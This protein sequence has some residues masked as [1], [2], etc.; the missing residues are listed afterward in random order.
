MKK[1]VFII[2]LSSFSLGA[3]SQI[4]D[5]K[6]EYDPDLNDI[7][8]HFSNSQW[9][10][11][12]DKA[13]K[14]LADIYQVLNIS[15][16]NIE[17]VECTAIHSS[18][19]A[20]L[21]A[22]TLKRYILINPNRLNNIDTHYFS[23]LFVIAHEFGHHR[24][25]HFGGNRVLTLEDKRNM[26]LEADRFG[27]SIV[28][29][30]G[31]SISDCVFALNEMNHP[32]NDTYYDHPTLE[33]RIKA[34]KEGFYSE[35]KIDSARHENYT[36]YL[37]EFS[38]ISLLS[39]NSTVSP[40]DIN[41]YCKASGLVPRTITF[42]NNKYWVYWKKDDNVASWQVLWNYSYDVSLLQKYFDLGYNLNFIEEIHGKWFMVFCKFN[43]GQ[44][45]QR[46]EVVRT[47]DLVVQS[48]NYKDKIESKLNDGY[49]I[50]DL[51][52]YNTNGD[53]L[54]VLSKKIQE[55]KGWT[56]AIRN[57]YEDISQWIKAQESVGFNYLYTYK[58]VNNQFF[59]FMTKASTV[60]SWKVKSFDGT[61]INS[62]KNLLQDGYMVGN[63]T[64]DPYGLRFTMVKFAN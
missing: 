56:W 58:I 32:V 28:R 48:Q 29:K 45:G 54:I 16:Y 35:S 10:M 25:N 12:F 19:L 1:L 2:L 41:S 33:K 24:L 26:E 23:H 47:Q 7:C 18:A 9:G 21:D 4:Y 44:F 49:M 37:N 51:V 39:F 36:N 15:G 20:Y 46:L 61:N 57:T 40:V 60:Y 43:S 42:F 3:F 31:G 13:K 62:V 14:N 6:S 38:D 50:Q 64:Y 8:A 5:L 55:A 11:E 17:I 63:M 53:V 27:A 30:D 59:G 22:K 34:V 52:S